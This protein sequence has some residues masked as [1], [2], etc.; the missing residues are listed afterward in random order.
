M[1]TLYAVFV[2]LLMVSMIAVNAALAAQYAVWWFNTPERVILYG[3][4]L[5][6]YS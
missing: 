4:L 2:C 6:E 5:G 1:R 3:D